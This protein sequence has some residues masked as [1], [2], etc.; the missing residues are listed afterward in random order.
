MKKNLLI[1]LALLLVSVGVATAFIIKRNSSR[2]SSLPYE[3]ISPSA[4]NQLRGYKAWQQVTSRIEIMP[5]V[6]AEQC[7]VFS[8]DTPEY[9][10][11]MSPANPHAK[12]YFRVYVNEIGKTA[13]LSSEMP[14]F[15]TGSVIVKEKLASPTSKSPELLTVM[16]KRHPGY[17]KEWGDWEY[18]VV[19]GQATKIEASGWL[20]HCY[21][22]H[23]TKEYNDYIFR[24]Y[25]T[26]KG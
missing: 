1:A 3:A 18:M 24:S 21:T 20:P 23:E 2:I 17:H 13:M 11:E 10:A 14:R 4:L 15:P 22:C 19:N 16:V 26:V 9:R 5:P 7:A 6:V 25:E 12:K 8:L